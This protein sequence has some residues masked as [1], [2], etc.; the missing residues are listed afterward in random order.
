MSTTCAHTRTDGT[1]C[2]ATAR[3]G[4]TVCLFHDPE[5]AAQRAEGRKRGGVVRSAKAATLPAD[6][7]DLPL[8]TVADV[9]DALT[10]TFNQVRTGR[11]DAR[12]GNCLGVLAGVILK[13]LEGGE[14]ERRLA[15][16]EA[17]G[18]AG[19]TR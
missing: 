13:A 3:R 9:V 14:V 11:L 7:G 5:L 10:A 16:L 8:R 4:R 12:V 1:R 19:R 18:P 15:E 17:G 6:A 2:R